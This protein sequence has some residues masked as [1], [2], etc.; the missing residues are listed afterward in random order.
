MYYHQRRLPHWEMIGQP[1]FVSFRLYDSL[2]QGRAFPPERLASGEAFVAMDR[3]LDQRRKGPRFMA[4]PQIAEMIIQSLH[5]GESRFH[6]YELH[7]FVVLP[8]HVHVLVTPSVN[9]KQWLGPLKGCTAHQAN[10]MLNRHAP[11]WEPESY[12]HLVRDGAEF[13]RIRLYIEN[14]PVKAGLVSW[15]EEFLWSSASPRR[16]P[17]A[18]LKG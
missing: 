4:E 14:N 9:S 12:N 15:P 13:R 5:N 10:R 1:L 17:A 3:L 8:N 7:S 2:P 6:R 11:F 16:S 18:A